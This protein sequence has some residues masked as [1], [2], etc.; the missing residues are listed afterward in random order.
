MLCCTTKKVEYS[1]LRSCIVWG[2]V[3]GFYLYELIL[4]AAPGVM[5]DQLMQAFT[6]NATAIGLL[7]SSYYYPYFILQI[8]CGLIVD[9]FGVR[10]VVTTSAIITALG[11]FLFAS[12]TNYGTAVFGQVLIGAGASCAFLSSLRVSVDWFSPSRFAL[13]SGL[14]NL[15]G[16]LGSLFGQRPLAV[17]INHQGWRLSMGWAAIAGVGIALLI[18]LV[19]R[20]RPSSLNPTETSSVSLVSE[21][22]FLVKMREIWLMGLV[23][24]LTYIPFGSFAIIW[25]IPFLMQLYGVD[26]AQ[27]S[28]A[29]SFLIIGFGLGGPVSVFLSDFL[30][31]RI[32]TVSLSTCIA[33][34]LFIV[35]IFVPHIPIKVMHALLFAAGLFTG[36]QILCFACA[37]EMVP[38]SISGTTLGLINT[39]ITIITAVLVQPLLGRLLDMAWDGQIRADGVPLYSQGAF[40]FAL[41]LIPLSLFL[42]VF[43]LLFIRET[44]PRE[45]SSASLN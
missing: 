23:A 26:S 11:C 25:S 12:S 31:R 13:L 30:K 38:T 32:L 45:E 21:L 35:I 7:T 18:W 14:T 9:R 2:C 34:F 3:A 33:A 29:N 1:T 5:T 36:A 27:A 40:Q 10:S 41:T 37:K 39:I 15:M 20:D 43:I 4:R 8:P 22:K 16:I 42:S 17:L 28:T 44:Y 6:I 24:G 19:V